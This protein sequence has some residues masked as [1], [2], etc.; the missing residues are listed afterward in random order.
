LGTDAGALL[1]DVVL[2]DFLSRDGSYEGGDE[3]KF[4]DEHYDG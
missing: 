4:V 2:V 1:G 3:R